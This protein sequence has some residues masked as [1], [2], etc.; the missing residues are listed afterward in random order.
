MFYLHKKALELGGLG[1]N[2]SYDILEKL[3]NFSKP[4][5]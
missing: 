4:H 5:M 1:S 2:S 3:F